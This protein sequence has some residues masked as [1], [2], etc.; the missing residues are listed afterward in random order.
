MK[1]DNEII[2]LED[3][4]LVY[5]NQ[6]INKCVLKNIN[7]DIYPQEFVCMLGPSGCGKTSLL[8]L[9]AGFVKPSEGKILFRGEEIEGVSRHRGVVFQESNLYEWMNVRKNI[10]F[11]LC[12]RK[13]PKEEIKKKTDNVLY[14]VG[15][16]DSA[17]KYIYELSGGMKQRVG[18]ARILVNDP[19]IFLMDEPFSSLDALNREKMQKFVREIWKESRKTVLFITHDVDEALMLGTRIIVIGEIPGRILLNESV[20]YYKDFIRDDCDDVRF[21]KEYGETRKKL[22]SYIGTN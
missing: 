17:E 11:G 6:K 13:L 14:K 9:I 2:K 7:L 1:L 21:S 18:I 8:N 19:E 16:M 10:D 20:R 4:S 12:M 22:L 3:V 5:S 15:L